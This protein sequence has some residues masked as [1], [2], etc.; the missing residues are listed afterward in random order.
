MSLCLFSLD[1]LLIYRLTPHDRVC[2]YPVIGPVGD[3]EAIAKPPLVFGDLHARNRMIP[4]VLLSISSFT[5]SSEVP[6]VSR[7]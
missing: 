2:E 3:L 5:P 6:Q 7:S 1:V 4:N